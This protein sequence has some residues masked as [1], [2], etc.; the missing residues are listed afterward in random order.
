MEEP[1]KRAADRFYA[2]CESSDEFVARHLR[3][4]PLFLPVHF[5]V[6]RKS[7]WRFSFGDIDFRP[8]SFKRGALLVLEVKGSRYRDE[9]SKPRI[10]WRL[11][12]YDREKRDRWKEDEGE[13]EAAEG[14]RERGSEEENRSARIHSAL[15]KRGI[16]CRRVCGI[17]WWSYSV[18]PPSGNDVTSRCNKH[19]YKWFLRPVPT[20]MQADLIESR[21]KR[22]LEV[23]DNEA[24]LG[25]P[26]K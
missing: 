8:L 7:A 12:L 26:N 13:E 23:N 15:F 11:E 2:K 25:L 16:R 24:A 17:R 10:K 19:E 9:F 22:K 18:L 21:R 3:F 14:L 20:V 5:L 4:R 1:A 6:R